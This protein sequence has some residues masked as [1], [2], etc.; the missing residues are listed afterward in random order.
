VVGICGE[1]RAYNKEQKQRFTKP[2]KVSKSIL[3]ELEEGLQSSEEEEL[4]TTDTVNTSALISEAENI[5]ASG[6]IH[7]PSLYT[8]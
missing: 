6:T 5:Q 1:I 2:I 7:L 4:A 8:Q 3:D